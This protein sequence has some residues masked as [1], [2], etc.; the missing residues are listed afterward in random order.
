MVDGP[1]NTNVFPALGPRVVSLDGT[2][3]L[4]SALTATDY[5]PAGFHAMRPREGGAA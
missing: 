4:F 5:A 1:A 2:P 3:D